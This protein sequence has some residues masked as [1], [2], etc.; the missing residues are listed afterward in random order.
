MDDWL[1]A[2]KPLARPLHRNRSCKPTET[3][4]PERG[5]G[6]SVA[7]GT[8]VRVVRLDERGLCGLDEQGLACALSMIG[9]TFEVDEIDEHGRPCVTKLFP[10][11][12]EDTATLH[13]IALNPDEFEVVDGA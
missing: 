2:A 11:E 9:E 10:G 7:V 3:P 8:L 12:T 5:R 13:S 1:L 6:D 4:V